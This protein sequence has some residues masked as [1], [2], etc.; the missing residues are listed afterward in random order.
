MFSLLLDFVEVVNIA[1]ALRIA[2]L[3]GYTVQNIILVCIKTI[4]SCLRK[5]LWLANKNTVFFPATF[6]NLQYKQRDDVHCLLLFFQKYKRSFLHSFFEILSIN[7]FGWELST[8]VIKGSSFHIV[9]DNPYALF[10]Y[11]NIK[12]RVGYLKELCFSKA[13]KYPFILR[14]S[15]QVQKSTEGVRKSS[16]KLMSGEKYIL[17][18]DMLSLMFLEKQDRGKAKLRSVV[19]TNTYLTNLFGL[20]R[21]KVHL[22]STASCMYLEKLTLQ[23]I[24]NQIK[25]N[26]IYNFKQYLEIPFCDCYNRLISCNFPFRR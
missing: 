26:R 7:I 5:F 18:P 24:Y 14:E 11:V 25:G 10:G 6:T 13:Q 21:R 15:G 1:T 8:I 12:T 4:L 23:L 19:C 3:F 2:S 17:T 16:C 22:P 9:D 20:F